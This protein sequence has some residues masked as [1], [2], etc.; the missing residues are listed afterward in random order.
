M[1]GPELDRLLEEH[2]AVAVHFWAVWDLHDRAMDEA[3]VAVRARLGGVYRFVS[4][5]MDD[6]ANFAF[7]ARFRILSIPCLALFRRGFDTPITLVGVRPPEQLERV[8]T[9]FA[10]C[11]T[12]T[13]AARI[14][15]E[16]K[17]PHPLFEFFLGPVVFLWS[18]SRATFRRWRV[19]RT[20]RRRRASR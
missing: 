14:L 10:T 8:L 20:R 3:V 4:C 11:D 19:S 18:A 15:R 5:D 17:K 6:P 7:A 13:P 16:P 1:T 2:D 9:G 12:Q